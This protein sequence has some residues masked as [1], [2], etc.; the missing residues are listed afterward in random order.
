MRCYDARRCYAASRARA[1]R[2]NMPLIVTLCDCAARLIDTCWRVLARRHARRAALICAS[3][4][5]RARQEVRAHACQRAVMRYAEM[6]MMTA[7]LR[8]AYARLSRQRSG[9][10]RPARATRREAERKIVAR[11][12]DAAVYAYRRAR[13]TVAAYTFNISHYERGA[14]RTNTTHH[15]IRHA[16]TYG[17]RRCLYR[18]SSR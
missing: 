1:R 14:R 16:A 13:V 5:V 2:A 8:G 15:E 6:L 12:C 18:L 4:G 7:M 3:A 17:A 9:A 10:R 11:P